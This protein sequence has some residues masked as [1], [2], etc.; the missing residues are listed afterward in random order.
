MLPWPRRD[1]S[2]RDRQNP[3]LRRRVAARGR[4]VTSLSDRPNAPRTRRRPRRRRAVAPRRRRSARPRWSGRLSG[5]GG[6]RK[7]AWRQCGGLA[8]FFEGEGEVVGQAVGDGLAQVHGRFGVH[9]GF[10]TFQGGQLAGV[11]RTH[12]QRPVDGNGGVPGQR[13]LTDVGGDRLQFVGDVG[14]AVRGDEDQLDLGT[15]FDIVG[16]LWGAQVD[17]AQ[18]DRSGAGAGAVHGRFLRR[19]LSH[20]AGTASA[21]HHGRGQSTGCQRCGHDWGAPVQGFHGGL[22]LGRRG[23]VTGRCVGGH[24][25]FDYAE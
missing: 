12:D 15:G 22:L 11:R 8:A 7:Q 21:E 25:G 3:P 6:W 24:C 17:V 9:G 1:G 4:S 23:G 18:V 20:L 10:D 5:R 14:R 19:G 2:G 16:G 13:H